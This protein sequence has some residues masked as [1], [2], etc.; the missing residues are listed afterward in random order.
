MNADWN[1]R[2]QINDVLTNNVDMMHGEYDWDTS[3]LSD[4]DYVLIA[5]TMDMNNNIV[6]DTVEITISNS[7]ADVMVSD[8][9]ILDTSIGSDAFVKNGDNLEI[10]AGITGPTTETTTATAD[11]S[12]FGMG[13]NVEATS[14]DGFTATWTLQNVV[15]LP[16]DGTITI[17][18]TVNNIH[19]NSATITADN[20]APE[21]TIE[22]PLNGL[23][24]FN[25]KLLTLSR[26]II[27]GPIDIELEGSSDIAKAEFYIDNELM[28]TV[29]SS[30][31]EWYM[32]IKLR[33]QHNLEIIVYD[34]AGNTV[35]ESKMIKVYNFFGK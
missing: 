17:T 6:H 24:F 20:T 23:Y 13:T 22:K 5:E 33:G 11:L 25:G 21:M 26:T 12:G 7:N 3:A 14:F 9:H 8:V 4:G 2:R 27:I 31:P 18:V 30:T 29:T 15:C 35:T 28:E 34:H 10:T 1:A 32:N 16:S 19:S